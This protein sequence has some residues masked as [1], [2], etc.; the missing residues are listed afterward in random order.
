ML[1]TSSKP[2][3][4]VQI[5][6]RSLESLSLKSNNGIPRPAVRVQVSGPRRT[7]A[8]LSSDTRQRHL[9]HHLPKFRTGESKMSS[10]MR[11]FPDSY[12]SIETPLP[13]QPSMVDNCDAFY[14]VKANEFCA[15]IV[16]KSGISLAQ[17]QQWNPKAGS[18]CAG[19]WAEA[20]AC[21]SIVGHTPTPTQPGNGIST[22]TPIQSGMVSNCNKF[23]FVEKDQTC[24]VIQAKYGVS[25]ANLYRW[26][27]AIKADC[28][29][30]WA[31]TYLCVGVKA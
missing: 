31:Q 18:N 25:L 3:R 14:F 7:L 23:H 21:V 16:Q 28:T 17:F 19:L 15:D 10:L 6:P 12:C 1:F 13:T 20:Y 11:Q 8:Y 24:P 4:A 22:P 29:G 30:M 9:L 27:P 26:N 5:S 2:V